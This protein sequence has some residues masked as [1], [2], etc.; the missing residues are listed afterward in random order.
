M[1]KKKT[2]IVYGSE[3]KEKYSS[4][5]KDLLTYYE[6]LDEEKIIM[7]PKKEHKCFDK[8]VQKVMDGYD[9][10]NFEI[11]KYASKDVPEIYSQD[12]LNNG[13]P[14][15]YRPFPSCLFRIIRTCFS[16]SLNCYPSTVGSSRA[17]QDLVNYLIK[18]GF[19]KEDNTYCNGINV[20]NV[21][22]ASS[23][24]QAF[25]MILKVIARKHDVII[26]PAPTYGIFA[27]IAEKLGVT[28]ETIDLKE[29]N[30]G[31][32]SIVVEDE[33]FKIESME[34]DEVLEFH[35]GYTIQP[36]DL[37]GTIKNSITNLVGVPQPTLPRG[38][39]VPQVE[40]TPSKVIY[41]P[42]NKVWEDGNNFDC[43]RPN[44]VT[45]YLLCNNE[46]AETAILSATNDWHYSFGP[47]SETNS[48][49]GEK[50][51][52]EI[53]EEPVPGYTSRIEGENLINTHEFGSGSTEV[54]GLKIWTD[55]SNARGLRPASIQINL[56]QNGILM[57]NVEPTWEYSGDV[58]TF[59]FS[60][61]PRFDS[62]G[63]EY[64]YTVRESTL[65][66]YT[67][68]Y[69]DTNMNITNTIIPRKI[70]IEGHKI[71]ND[72]DNAAGL[73]PTSI[74]VRLLRDNI[75]IMEKIV[76]ADDG[77]AYSFTDLPETDPDTGRLY[78]YTIGEKMV[79]G[80]Y[81]RNEGYNL[82][83][84]LLPTPPTGGPV[85]P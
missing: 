22:F 51:E 79:E 68:T 13:N 41:M 75:I 72:D 37:G 78:V 3:S 59:K 62:K 16:R 69:D 74:T 12:S 23:T 77:W 27:G 57:P 19:P 63:N 28:C 60:N 43:I 11:D 32:K 29:E 25:G 66:D 35:Y 2:N 56:Y 83:N 20:H 81:A 1:N 53:Q 14:L 80:Y 71:W 49:T 85:V 64:V 10:V 17:R 36:D 65:D 58:W 34:P 44:Q 33:K 39:K 31:G 55:Q 24:T 52:Y 15:R 4:A 76:T 18:E 7:A 8:R 47:L 21:A 48:D 84:N 46:I 26:I 38:H 45:V 6:E 9:L 82:I 5:L 50:Y 42:I 67:T 61:V 40:I 70:K 73:R 30:V 54:S